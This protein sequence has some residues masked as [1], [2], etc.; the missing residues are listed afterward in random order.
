MALLPARTHR[1][2]GFA[3]PVRFFFFAPLFFPASI[4]F[5]GLWAFLQRTCPRGSASQANFRASRPSAHR[6]RSSLAFGVSA[7]ELLPDHAVGRVI[8]I[9]INLYAGGALVFYSALTG[10]YSVDYISRCAS[11]GCARCPRIRVCSS[12]PSYS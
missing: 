1:R 12:V 4:P 8:F 9:I 6:R 5:P 11:Q 3:A 7:N 10:D 2:L